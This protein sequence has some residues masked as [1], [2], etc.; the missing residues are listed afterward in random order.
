MLD[1]YGEKPDGEGHGINE[2]GDLTFHLGN[3]SED[4]LQDGKQFYE[5]TLSQNG[6]EIELTTSDWGNIPTATPIICLLYTS[7]SPRDS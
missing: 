6:E 3:V 2:R 4:I 1:P 7:P 5:N